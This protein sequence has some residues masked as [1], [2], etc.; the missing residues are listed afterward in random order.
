M[1]KFHL[2]CIGIMLIISGFAF[3]GTTGKLAGKV[4][5][6][7]GNPIPFANITI[8]DGDTLITGIMTKENGSYFI[9]NITLGIYD[10]ICMR[11]GFRTQKRTGVKI[12]RDL[13]QIEN[14]T[15]PQ[16]A[17][18][19]EGFDVTES[20]VEMVQSPKTSS[21]KTISAAEMENIAVTQIEDVIAMQAG[22]TLNNREIH[23]RGSRSN[24]M[25]YTVDGMSVSDPTGVGFR[26][27]KWNT[28]EYGTIV[29]N[30]FKKVIDTPISTFSI[31]VDA[32]SYANMRR[33]INMGQ[34]PYHGAVRIEEMINYFD[35]DYPQ[36]DG[37]DPFS[38]YTEISDC[39]WNENHKL[40]HIGLQGKKLDISE[41]PQSNLVFLIDVSGS[42][43]AENKLEL[44]KK[45]FKLLVQ[46][47]KP[48][49]RISIV[50]YA[51]AAGIVLPPTPG[52]NKDKIM[53]AINNLQAGGSTAG[54]AGIRLAYQTAK[55]NFIK[56]GNNR[57]IL[58]TDGDFNIGISSTSEL[59][60]YIEQERENGIFLT[61]LGFGMRNY[62]DN[63]MEQLADKGNG[64]YYYIDNIL[65][66][67]K[68]FVR[69]LGGTLFTI[70]KD[71]K[72]QLEFNPLNVY[73]Y[74]LVGYENRLLNK[75]DFNDDTKDTGELGAG[76]TVTALYELILQ[77]EENE[78][79]LP[80]V[81]EL[82]YQMKKITNEAK[83]SNEF[84]TLKLRY[85]Q[86]DGD[87]SKLLEFV[88]KDKI[89]SL[90]KTSNNFRFS[91]AIA[92]FGM[93]LRD[94]KFK[95]DITYKSLIKLAKDAKGKDNFGYRAE[96][97]QLIEKAEL[98]EVIEK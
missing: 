54:G 4:K 95:G 49:D 94:S 65:E 83:Q 16:Q 42:M 48:E 5:D 22:V 78:I 2:I 38:V 56:K 17:I 60:A 6:E 14:F 3:A 91:A 44:V 81:D 40:M 93:L 25:F 33:F 79:E 24:E 98:I 97:I 62:K 18:A 59:T 29:E 43:R 67:K 87:K 26:R 85:K 89:L 84:L 20:K 71:V 23:V 76:H 41:T 32:A 51:G 19:I 47:L 68:V 7:R 69:E 75:E 30:E 35:Y 77:K 64:N 61:T 34:L 50:V 80:N 9:I 63:R 21:G 70:A 57:V 86:P 73:A 92:G 28:E 36:P 52:S 46:N 45:A 10:V 31:D 8:M 1:K 37:D 58:A 13:T 27:G 12:S 11:G 55:D 74:R 53:K 39:P 96:F 90:K 88:V 82:K 72:L 66:A 15:M